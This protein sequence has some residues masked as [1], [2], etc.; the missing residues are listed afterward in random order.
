M[1]TSGLWSAQTSAPKASSQ[2]QNQPSTAEP[3]HS[4]AYYHYMLA[5]RFKELAGIYN[6]S[7]YV[8]KAISEYKL[9]MEADPD[10]LFL[11]VEL[12]DL[13]WRISRIGDAVREAEAVLK[14]NPNQVD[15]HR[16]LG[17]IYLRNL[18][19]AQPDNVAK[20]SLHKAI[21]HFEALTRLK[22]SD[23][24][25]YITLGR[26][27]KLN[28]E[29]AKAEAAFKKILTSDPSSGN[30]LSSLAQLY[31]DQGDY[32]QAIEL[33]T[34]IPDTDMSGPLLGMLAYA[35]S[36]SHQ[37]DKAIETFE[38]A[39]TRDPENLDIRRAYVEALMDAGKADAARTELQTILKADPEDGKSFMRLA[40]LDR[41]EGRFDQARQELERAKTL[42]PDSAEVPFQQVLLEDAAGNQDKAIEIL[43]GLIKQTEKPQ[44]QYT[45]GEANNRAIFLERLGEIYRSQEKYD[46][47]IA[48]FKLIEALGKDQA[49]RGEGLVVETL[50]LSKQP[51]A[52][53]AEADAAVQKYPDDRPLR[54]LRASLLGEQGHVDEAIQ[55]LQ[56]MLKGGPGDNE[57]YL[58]MAQVYST[59]K[60]YPEAEIVTNKALALSPKPDDQEMARFMLGSIFER[61]KKWDLAEEQFKKVL[62]VDPLNAPASN[63]LGYMLAD[64]G[65]RLDES[66]KYIQKALQIDPNNGAYLDSLGWAYLKMNRVDLAEAPLEKAAHLI[67]GDPTVQ[68]HLGHLYF[69]MGK[70]ME[71]EQQ[72]EQALKEWPTALGSDFDAE[73]AAKLRKELDDLKLTLAKGKP[74]TH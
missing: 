44:G 53:L 28:N 45:I 23:T 15:A 20:D 66:V 54:R 55:Q 14:I 47:A 5:R 42:M 9:A 16:L 21:F 72:W 30:A 64:R 1:G 50:R 43:Q 31:T 70:K 59:A 34:K 24:D 18:S 57:I 22:P 39:M 32:A 37:S 56:G 25:S 35:Y 49:P 7:D 69:R 60:R 26:L 29:P 11:R 62:A 17:H 73:E 3:D 71:A 40:Q 74:A 65:V 41:Q 38:K 33:L 8:E 13:Y 67:P 19:E 48:E 52:A 63:Y 68:E 46:L 27:Y 6:R 61:Q 36:Q 2:P 58:S 4:Q 10:S 51:K 12:A